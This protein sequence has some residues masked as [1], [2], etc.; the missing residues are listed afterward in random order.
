MMARLLTFELN[1]YGKQRIF[2]ASAVLFFILGLLMTQGRFGGPEVYKNGPYVI[3]FISGLL[4]IALIFVSALLCVNAVLR[5]RTHGMQALIFTTGI[6]RPLYVGI[7]LLGLLLALSL[8]ASLALLGSMLGPWVLALAPL[9][10]F[11]MSYYGQAFF[12]FSLPNALFCGCFCF[13]AAMAKPKA[14][15][16]YAAAALLFMGYFAASIWGH[17]PLM[18]SS[19]FRPQAPSLWAQLVDPFGLVSF[20]GETKRWS[21]YQ[22]NYECYH[23]TLPFCVNRL[24]WT[25]ISALVLAF[26]YARYELRLPSQA[27]STRR[28]S[29][30][31]FGPSPYRPVATLARGGRYAWEVLVSQVGLELR[32]LFGQA[33]YLWVA[34]LWVFAYGVEIKENLTHG[35]Y[36]TRF[37][38]TTALVVEQLLP[39]RLALLLLVFYASELIYRSQHTRMQPLL[40]STPLTRP[41]VYLSKMATLTIVIFLL[42]SLHLGLGIAAQVLMGEEKIE[43]GPYLAL[44]YYSGY[45]LLLFAGLIVGIQTLISN[46]YLGMLMSLVVMASSVFGTTLGLEAYWLRFACAPEVTYSAISGFGHYARVHQ[47]YMLYWTLAAGWLAMLTMKLWPNAYQQTPGQRMK[48]ALG[49]WSTRE[50][51]TGGGILVLLGYTGFNIAQKSQGVALGAN[52]SQ[53]QR[54]QAR[55]EQVY[56]SRASRPQ[57]V[58]TALTLTTDLYPAQQRYVVSGRYQLRNESDSLIRVLW[59]GRD[60]SVTSLRLQVAGTLDC[61]ADEALGQFFYPLKQPLA[62]GQVIRVDFTMEVDR[63]GDHPFDSE[64]AVVSNGSY[65]ELEKF[66]PWVGYNERLELKDSQLRARHGLK[67]RRAVAETDGRYHRLTYE[68]TISTPAGQRV[69]TVGALKRTWQNAGRAYF[70]YQTEQPIEPMF[71]LSSMH[72]EVRTQQRDGITFQVYYHPGQSRNVPTMMESMQKTIRYA[73]RQWSPYPFK[74]VTLA[75][76]PAYGGA[77]T[78]YPGVI[79]SHEKY[80]FLLNASDTSRVNLVYAT[81]AHETAHQWWAYTIRPKAGPGEAFLTESLAKYTEAVIVQARQ[82]PLKLSSYL[83]ADNEL[84]FSQR[85]R[86]ARREL[87]LNQSWQQPYVHYQKGGLALYAL[88]QSLG[89]AWI[90]RA[91]RRL[92]HHQAYPKQKPV[93]QNLIDE[94]KGQAPVWKQ[95]LIENHLEKVVIYDNRIQLRSLKALPQGGY[96][97]GLRIG[98]DKTDQTAL[99]RL[100]I[101]DAVEI[102][103]WGAPSGPAKL[104]YWQTHHLTKRQT[105]LELRLDQKPTLVQVDPLHYLLDENL[106]N[107]TV[108]LGP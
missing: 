13:A 84:Y 97:L 7:K 108:A 90:N 54:W 40:L 104:L 52:R 98:V 31:S 57:P 88:G 36:D 70:Q 15:T 25:G 74:H 76:I 56:Q 24:L 33:T 27:S 77:A 2:Q 5:D 43:L 41:L 21:V 42:L 26:F 106:A 93:A 73:S 9:G 81:T 20:L 60:P 71:A 30:D 44:Y 96:Q 100:P 46:T 89:E 49:Q 8:I 35:P 47:G 65:I 61:Q 80:N 83:K 22:R 11:Q 32:L 6:G 45:P 66:I 94:L 82:G 67:P 51:L 101:N 29:T 64:N 39:V 99:Q 59:L 12:F 1:Y 10:R 58:L 55:Y 75:E 38:V 86:S 34:A 107:N 87:P 72:Y 85:N 53:D 14:S 50:L 92:I 19:A 18:A 23:L 103:V 48:A 69:V 3:T 68:N 102:A 28:L 105:L 37:Y 78:A 63:S 17:S 79:F 95:K 16:V 91:L 62:P 4:S